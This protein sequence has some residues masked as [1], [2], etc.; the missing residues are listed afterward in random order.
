[1][2]FRSIR[3]KLNLTLDQVGQKLGQTPQAIH[4]LEAGEKT[5]RVTLAAL[6]EAGKALG[7]ELVYGFVP[8]GSRPLSITPGVQAFS[9]QDTIKREYDRFDHRSSRE[10]LLQLRRVSKNGLVLHPRTRVLSLGDRSVVLSP[11]EA[12]TM[13]RL[14]STKSSLV[15]HETLMAALWIE[16]N[17]R[18]VAAFR[19]MISRLRS[20]LASIGAGDD[21]ISLKHG[22]GYKLNIPDAT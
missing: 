16:P 19:V 3:E 10:K 5:G 18:R 17:E 12:L 15:R 4:K 1:M 9:P 7:F 13:H 6:A 2:T 21:P 14:L 11:A 20:K 8:A 22:A